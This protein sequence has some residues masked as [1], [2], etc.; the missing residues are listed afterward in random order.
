MFEFLRYLLRFE[1][2][3]DN[4]KDTS[5]K[6]TVEDAKYLCSLEIQMNQDGTINIECCW[7]EFDESN[8]NSLQNIANN[9]A[10]VIDAI[11]QGYLSKDIVN[12]IKNYKSDNPFDILFAQNVFYKIAELNYLKTKNADYNNGPLVK[13]SQAFKHMIQS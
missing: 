3:S 10:L 12:T 2:S 1:N 5:K 11:N 13:P 4:S 7:P 8:K 9:Y 6:S